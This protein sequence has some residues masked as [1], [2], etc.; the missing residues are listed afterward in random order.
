MKLQIT[1]IKIVVLSLCVVSSFSIYSEDK[2]KDNIN[3]NEVSNK[4]QAFKKDPTLESSDANLRNALL[5]LNNISIS[6]NELP[7]S[8]FRKN[9]SAALKLHLEIVELFETNYIENY[10]PERPYCLNLLPPEGSVDTPVFG[11]VDPLQIKDKK[12]REKYISDINENNVIGKEIA[13]QSELSALKNTLQ[14]PDVK[15]GSIATVE[16]FIKKYYSTDS[17]DEIEIKEIIERSE[18]RDNLKSR[19]IKDVIK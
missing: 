15:S 14:A 13:F 11:S 17:V 19:I 1:L 2:M 8:N 12:T 16:C 9:R 6:H 3:L 7:L 10:K 5:I 18:L 4:I